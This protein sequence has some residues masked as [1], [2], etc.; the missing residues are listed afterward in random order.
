MKNLM[1]RLYYSICDKSLRWKIMMSITVTVL[2]MSISIVATI[3]IDQYAISLISST[4]KSNSDL[5]LLSN[6]VSCV[7]NAMETYMTYRTFESIDNYFNAC[8]QVDEYCDN[9]QDFPSTDSVKQKE[10]IVY[11]MAQSFLFY[12]G[13]AI[14]ARRA[15]GILVDYYYKKSLDCYK[16]ML[17]QISALNILLME[18]NSN[19]YSEAKKNVDFIIKTYIILFTI[20]FASILV[21]LSILLDS[22]TRP[23]GDISKVA[24]R[25]AQQDFDVPPFNRDG[26]DE[27][28]NICRA[29]DQMIVGVRD[30]IEMQALYSDA[31]L[32]AFQ[33]QINPHFLFNTL[34][35]GAQLAM[36]EGADKT[37]YFIEQTS[38]FFRYNLQ[39]Q[40]RD[41]TV[42]DELGLVDNFVY[43]MKVRFGPRL[44][45]EKNVDCDESYL[46]WTLPSMTLQ[47]L[48]ENCIKH[49]LENS[50]GKVS[51]NVAKKDDVVE[52]TVCDNGVG[53]DSSIREQILSAANDSSHAVTQFRNTAPDDVDG[54]SLENRSHAGI[55]LINVFS[56]LRLY[57][58]TTDVYDIAL[59]DE[60]DENG[61]AHGTKFIIRIK[62]NV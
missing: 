2:I 32:R 7:E 52:I 53:F 27:I 19:V 21:L 3:K 47:P 5:N 8:T 44:V 13:K 23:L 39:Q 9:M 16:L 26:H 4:Y 6:E 15:N 11:Q 10:Y 62:E 41:A 56:R 14:A 61:I 34:N 60:K 17:D 57:F 33:S 20:F 31:Q 48:V 46:S 49:G 38:D 51:L 55:G 29:F 1:L 36:M 22:I 35:T 28:G 45:F 58:H 43:I 30:Y 40:C 12:S 42:L 54:N 18:K 25:V 50:K 24:L 37:C 59:N